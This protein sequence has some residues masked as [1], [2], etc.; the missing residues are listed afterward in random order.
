[1]ADFIS[2]ISDVAL[3]F[4]GGGM[5]ASY[6]SGFVNV[7]LENELYFNHIYGVSAGSSNGVNYL[8]RDKERAKASFTDFAADPKFGNTRTFLT[9]RGLFNARYI[10]QESGRPEGVLPFNY[11][12]FESN[13][14]NLTIEGFDR[15]TGKTIYWRRNDCSTLDDL[16]LRVRASSSLPFFMPPAEVDGH[17]CYDGGLGE[18]SGIMVP[19]AEADGFERFVVVCTR[20][21]GYRKQYESSSLVDAFFWRRP[22]VQDAI[23]TRAKRY[24]EQLNRLLDLEAQGRA[25]VF[26]SEGQQV[27]SDERDIAVLHANYQR[28]Y[29]QARREL[30]ALTRFLQS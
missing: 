27:E 5:R 23:K 26:Y 18:G 8:S 12:A 21:K 16:M 19:C 24:N 7:L 2:N 11:S 25:F 28:G 22:Y 4:E 6:T 1:M 3:I 17:A 30:D 20:P 14:A 15:D 10:Y 9:G 29:E 13:P